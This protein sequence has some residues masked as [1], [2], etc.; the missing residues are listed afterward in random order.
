MRLVTEFCVVQTVFAR[1][2]TFSLLSS[3]YRKWL[4]CL[5]LIVWNWNRVG[6]GRY[7]A[8]RVAKRARQENRAG[9]RSI[10]SNIYWEKSTLLCELFKANPLFVLRITWQIL[11]R[12]PVPPT[13]IHGLSL[14]YSFCV[15]VKWSIHSRAR[16]SVFRQ[17]SGWR[18]AAH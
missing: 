7:Y 1:H 18:T 12:V 11:V 10:A 13:Y 4:V 6:I 9:N 3:T 8:T 14:I 5:R 16:G 17:Q 2:R 15:Y